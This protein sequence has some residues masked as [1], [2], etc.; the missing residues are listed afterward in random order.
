LGN[1]MILALLDGVKVAFHYLRVLM[2]QLQLQKE[3][4]R[5]YY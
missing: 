5:D 4:L 1:E 3:E 2:L